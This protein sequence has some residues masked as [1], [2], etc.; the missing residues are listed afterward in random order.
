[1]RL[2]NKDLITQFDEIP[3]LL[4]LVVE[5]ADRYSQEKY[6]QELLL[7]SIWRKK[8]TDSGVHQAWRAVDARDEFKDT[9]TSPSQ[10]Q[11]TDSQVRDIVSHINGKFPRIDGKKTCIHHA[12]EGG[13]LHFHFQVSAHMLHHAKADHIYRPNR[14][15]P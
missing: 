6:G 4:Q 12:V 9:L 3:T 11:F 1:M 15:R 7:T 5:E 10:R 14:Q 8:T 13:M 2:K